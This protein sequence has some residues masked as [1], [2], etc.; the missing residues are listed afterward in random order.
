MRSPQAAIRPLFAPPGLVR[1]SEWEDL[2]PFSDPRLQGH[3]SPSIG[4]HILYFSP[5]PFPR[6]SRPLLY[7]LCAGMFV[8]NKVAFSWEQLLAVTGRSPQANSTLIK[9]G[10]PSGLISGIRSCGNLP[11]HLVP[12]NGHVPDTDTAGDCAPEKLCPSRPPMPAARLSLPKRRGRSA[13]QTD[14]MTRLR[15]SGPYREQ[16]KTG[17]I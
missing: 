1:A 14:P 16:N 5:P 2:A 12:C 6:Y 7:S 3:C 15:R 17:S 13:N 11:D 8:S 10:F 4:S 9:W